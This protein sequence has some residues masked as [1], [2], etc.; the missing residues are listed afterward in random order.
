[1]P[2]RQLLSLAFLGALL[3]GGYIYYEE[4]VRAPDAPAAE[5]RQRAPRAVTVEVALAQS[6]SLARLVEAVGTTRA[7][8]SIEIVPQAEGQIAE[9][10]IEAGRRVNA[11]TVIA[12]LDDAIERATLAEA[13]ANLDQKDRALAR[14]ERLLG[15]NNVSES[16]VDVARS[17]RLVAQ[18]V[19]NR[20]RAN[21][22]DRIVRAPFGGVL[23][24]T[25]VHVGARVDTDTVL[26]SLDDLSAVEIEFTVPETLYGQISPGQPVNATTAAYEGRTFEGSVVAVDSR[27]D[28]TSR[29]FKVR[30]R[31]PNED[32]SL[33]AGMFMRLSLTLG[34]RDAVVVS[35][36]AIVLQAG[37]PI[38]FVAKEGTAARRPIETGTRR[39]SMVEVVNGVDA[40][41]AVI[42]RGVQSLQDGS[43]IDVLNADILPAAA[44][45]EAPRERE[46]PSAARTDAMRRS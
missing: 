14:F 39:E 46:A 40:G 19:L 4:V 23:G 9:I 30:A 31:L 12:R 38:V 43:R 27:V 8:R 26:A 6:R 34:D 25:S 28:P 3:V 24:I 1:M 32:R 11:G 18:A 15:S 21:V 29:A 45:D 44:S 7:L 2:L 42:V 10:D 13:E 17:E 16:A 36:E 20:A 33:P 35:E 41:E 22:A 37:Q 5:A